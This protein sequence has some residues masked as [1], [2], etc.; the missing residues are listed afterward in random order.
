MNYL[1]F[2]KFYSYVLLAICLL[3]FVNSLSIF[4][5]S[6]GILMFIDL[7]DFLYI[8]DIN[9]VC[10]LT[11]FPFDRHLKFNFCPVVNAL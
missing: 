2:W 11:Y 8:H 9:P 7:C 5:F 1:Y 10:R 3:S 6:F 4:Y